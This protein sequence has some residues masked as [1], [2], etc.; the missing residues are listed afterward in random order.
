M[1]TDLRTRKLAQLAV[2]KCIGI[3]P[4]QKII[5]SGGSEATPFLVELYKESILQ[6]AIP[7]VKVGLPDV[8]DFFYKYATKEQLENFPDYWFDTIK[9]V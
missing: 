8:T 2:R 3:K 9:Q 7:I 1:P 5:L 4:G 6:K